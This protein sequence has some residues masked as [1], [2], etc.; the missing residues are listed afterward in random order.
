[1]GNRT[2]RPSGGRLARL[3]AFARSLASG[4]EAYS[5]GF[6]LVG[7]IVVPCLLGVWLDNRFKT[8]FWTPLL[9]LLGAGAGFREMIRTAGAL[10]KRPPKS[11]VPTGG[12]PTSTRG[13]GRRAA[14]ESAGRDAV[15]RNDAGTE[16]ITEPDD[17]PA[18]EVERP[19]PRIFTVPPPPLPGFE[20]GARPRDTTSTQLGAEP[21]ADD[22]PDDQA[23][24]IRRLL[25]EP[26]EESDGGGG[27]QEK[28]P[29]GRNDTNYRRG[30]NT[31][32]TP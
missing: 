1:M 21:S 17:P 4:G 31:F 8:S 29:D 30:D 12:P 5:I 32:N 11:N 19:R 9:F 26:E 15:G 24:L 10:S 28:A 18:T 14:G 23:E 20:S 2:N 6:V 25:G 27:D 3:N 13:A 7:S 22:V 16:S